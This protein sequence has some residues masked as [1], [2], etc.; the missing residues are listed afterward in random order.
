MEGDTIMKVPFC[1]RRLPAAAEPAT[2][3]LLVSH[4]VDRLLDL[5]A[6]IGADPLPDIYL[7]AD[8]FLL[9]VPQPTTEV[10]PGTVRL[11]AL[12]KNLL[13]PADAILAPTLYEDEAKGLVRDRGLVFLPGG[14]VLEFAPDQPVSLSALLIVG[15]VQRQAWQPFPAPRRHAERIEQIALE[16]P[17]ESPDELLD[18]GGEGIG[19]ED[20]R[21]EDSNIGARAAGRGAVIAGRGLLG[22]G[23]LLGLRS[24]A[25]LGAQLIDRGL[26]LAPRLSEGLL[27]RQEAALRALLSKFR[28]GKLEE[29]LRRALPLLGSGGRGAGVP[30]GSSRLP[31]QNLLYSLGNLLGTGSGL[32]GVWF[33]GADLQRELAEE[34]RK[35]A[36]QA[37]AAGDYRRAAY[38]YGKLLQDFR[39]AAN[40]LLQGGL[41][42]DAAILYLTKVGDPLAAARAFEAAGEVDRALQ[43]YRQHG[44]HVLAG[45]LLRRAGEDEAALVEY[46]MAADNMVATDQD[47]LA[48]GELLLNKTGRVDL[49]LS[50]FETNWSLRPAKNDMRC[51][52]RMAQL[53][54]ERDLPDKL[55]KLLAEADVFLGPPGN[56]N[57]AGQFYNQLALLAERQNLAP[58][59]EELRDRALLGLA[60]KLRQRAEVEVR[61][62]NLITTLLGQSS[63]WIP[64]VVSDADFA[65]RAAMK[66]PRPSESVD[67]VQRTL[68]RIQ[69]GK[70]L[71]TAVCHAPETGSVFVGFET[72]EIVC[73]RPK[74][75]EVIHFPVSTSSPVT[76][77][78]TD[79]GGDYVVALREDVHT[80]TNLTSYAR[81][82]ASGYRVEGQAVFNAG[83]FWLTPFLAGRP[84]WS[85]HYILAC[86]EGDRI[87]FLRGLL[88]THAGS[89]VGPGE[90][91]AFH[92]GLVL[93][94][95]HHPARLAILLFGS[96]H[97]WYGEDL[98]EDRHHWTPVRWYDTGLSWTPAR[99]ED[100]SLKGP[101]WSWLITDQEHLEL[102]GL[103][104]HGIVYWSKLHVGPDDL[105]VVATNVSVR[106]EGYLAA[107]LVRPGFVAGVSRAHVD[108][109][110]SGGKNFS[111]AAGAPTRIPLPTALACFPSHA[112]NELIVICRDGAIVRIPIPT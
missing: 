69:A 60:S 61:P 89:L 73:F 109:L 14:R 67:K 71:V 112:T 33:G 21:P 72:G 100:T 70:G 28:E 6:R 76:S 87:S 44:E 17:Q 34:Y 106:A 36:Q 23:N 15:R 32:G 19:T 12:A 82:G 35:A 51:A 13:L 85:N 50:Y 86:L 3:F 97:V 16:L 31:F 63:A 11:R 93:P 79:A 84:H 59:R 29:A 80:P 90:G 74:R 56:E 1:L 81:S 52:G 18:M 66:L 39:A 101:P 94:S 92:G 95:F 26:S 77:L 75:D 105:K 2:A 111:L 68:E 22:L 54:A 5:C 78:A 49:A 55:L 48:A 62:G 45:D 20:P 102:A 43:L 108:W 25:R 88:L 103:A 47:Y 65:V 42:H 40:V 107:C 98:I 104:A 58:L 41:C 91:F 8:G 64:A 57:A 4:E 99:Q 46:Q 9:L 30:S 27:G 24:L 38:I 83:R 110:R 96:N 53:F 10:F 37:A 7:V